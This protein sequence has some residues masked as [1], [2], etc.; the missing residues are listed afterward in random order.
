VDPELLSAL[1]ALSDASRL[2]IV[3]LLAGGRRLSVEELAAALALT[4]GTVVHHMKRL[5]DSGLVV[6]H[7]RHPYVEYELR[8]PRLASIG[9]DLDRIGREAETTGVELPGPDCRPRP[10]FEAKVLRA[11]IGSDGRLERI[12]AQEKKRLVVMRY[13]AETVFKLGRAYPEKEV[14]MALALLHPDVAS[15]RRFL[16]DLG[17]MRRDAGIYE[18]RPQSEWPPAPVGEDDRPAARPADQSTE[19]TAR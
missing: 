6:A 17:F 12:P 10:A 9:A 11:F 13:V 3:G 4:P 18:L 19:G 1:K 14:N 8:L 16:V 7:P 2:R 15:L 5:R